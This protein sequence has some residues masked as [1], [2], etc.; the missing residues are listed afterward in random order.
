MRAPPGAA[1]FLDRDGT[2]NAERHYLSRPEEF[3]LLPGVTVAL[4]RLQVAG[5]RL[6]VVTNQSGIGRGYFTPDNL[7]A[8]HARMR[9][10]LACDGVRF[11]KIYVAPEAPD[12]PSRYRKPSPRALQDARDEFGV[13]LTRS[14]MI[15]DKWIDVETGRAAGCAASI[16]VR[17]G[18]G[19]ETERREA[20]RLGEAVVVDDL[21]AAAEWILAE[22]ATPAGGPSFASP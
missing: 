6:F 5:F 14:V 7:E 20:A 17:T 8:V 21:T 11:E 13:D 1:V 18:Y 12:Q 22:V 9:D 4:K 10:L 3:V 16:L 15:G 19:A 2:L